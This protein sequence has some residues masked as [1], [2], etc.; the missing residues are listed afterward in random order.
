MSEDIG[1]R[2]E[3]VDTPALWVD[4]DA[5]DANIWTMASV[6]RDAGVDWRPHIKASKSPALAK[7]L[8]DGG[9]VGIT[10]AKVGEAEVMADGGITD[11]LI[12]NEVIGP[13]KIARLVALAARITIGVAV[14]DERNLRELSAA[15]DSAGVSIDVLVDIN[16]GM[17]RCGIPPAEAPAL[18][19]LVLDLPGVALRGL[20]GYEGHVMGIS[21][22]EEKDAAS[23]VVADVLAAGVTA[24]EGAGIEARVRS[25]GGTGNYWIAAGLGALTELQAGGGV[26]MDL[27]YMEKMNVPG[28]QY[29]LFLTEQVVST[30][31]PGRVIGDAGWKALGYHTGSPQV[32]APEGV[33]FRA[34]NAE[35]G[36]FEVDD[37]VELNPGDRLTLIPHYSDSTVLLHRQMYAVRRGVVEEVWPIAAAGMLQ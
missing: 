28:H 25:G 30:Q 17:S 16:V 6:C 9:A 7:R 8:V 24:L 27:T 15:A 29:A 23:R 22:V 11:I 37:G 18:A 36:I 32:V 31:T 1:R 35:H 13:Q 34:P 14:D 33:R 2:I 12:A 19:Q 26:L 4:L 10:C 21:D 20:M 5:L 3:E